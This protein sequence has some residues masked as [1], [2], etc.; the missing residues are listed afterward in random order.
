VFGV[1]KSDTLLL[2]IL[3]INA[4]YIDTIVKCCDIK[5]NKNDNKVR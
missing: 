1:Y 5:L 2:K 3:N 4:K